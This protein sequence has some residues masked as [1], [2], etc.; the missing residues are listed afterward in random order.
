MHSLNAPKEG[1]P[2]MAIPEPTKTSFPSPSLVCSPKDRQH[3]PPS[4]CTVDSHKVLTPSPKTK[5]IYANECSSW[6]VSPVSLLPPYF[7]VSAEGHGCVIPISAGREHK[8][9][10]NKVAQVAASTQIYFISLYKLSDAI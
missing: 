1:S 8:P 5:D 9:V 2:V 6:P 4:K 7:Q 10:R 3:E